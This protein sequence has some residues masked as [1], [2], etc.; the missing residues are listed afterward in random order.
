[1]WLE[2]PC[3]FVLCGFIIIHCLVRTGLAV[4]T[5][6]EHW[7]SVWAQLLAVRVPS[8]RQSHYQK[9]ANRGFFFFFTVWALCFP[10]CVKLRFFVEVC[11]LHFNICWLKSSYVD[12][13]TLPE[14]LHKYHLLKDS[15]RLAW[16][17]LWIKK[18]G[19]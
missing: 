11:S 3:Y 2:F 14:K 6:W 15:S 13:R 9:T 5:F 10:I 8:N 19:I 12:S 4:I 1:M 16:R 18:S 7:A 17:N